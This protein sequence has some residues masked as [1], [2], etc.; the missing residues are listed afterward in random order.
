LTIRIALLPP[1]LLL[2]VATWMLAHP[3]QGIFHDA[4]LYTLQALAH[5]H[6]DTL[7]HDVFLRFG[8]QDRFTIFSP[9]YALT[10]R[11][12]GVDHAAALLTLVSQVALFVGGWCLA[13]AVLSAEYA[14]LGLVLIVAIPGDYGPARVF[15]CVEPFLT[16]RMGAEALVLAAL[17][18]SFSGR[19]RWGF[20]LL[21]AAFAL[22]PVMAAAGAAAW[23]SAAWLLPNPR[24]GIYLLLAATVWLLFASLALPSGEW[25]GIDADWLAIA[26][27]R[28]PYLFLAFWGLDDWGPAAV[29]LTILII[30]SFTLDSRARLLCRAAALT[31]VGGFL[32]T[33]FAC[34]FLHLT[35]FMQVQPWRWQWLGTLVAGLVLPAMIMVNWKRDIA[36]RATALLTIAAWIFGTGEFAIICCVAGLLSLSFGRLNARQIR[37]VFFGSCAVLAI[38]LAW[39][40][41]TNLEFSAAHYMESS[42]PLWLRRATSFVHDGFAPAALLC[43]V[44]IAVRASRPYVAASTWTVLG[45][46]AVAG[47][48]PYAWSIWTKSEFPQSLIVSFAPW[49]NLIASDEEVFW[50]ES[51]LSTWVLLDRPSYISGL[52]TSGV[53]FSRAS[54]LEL[55]RRAFALKSYVSPG[56]FLAWSSVGAH[57]SLSRDAMQGICQMGVFGY[58]VTGADLGMQP[59]AVL[60]RLKLYA[61][62]PQARAAAAA[63]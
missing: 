33:G 22:H 25:G 50:G 13:R 47:L 17:A 36:G 29:S 28:S 1:V 49:R 7:A 10:I 52:Q 23:L 51:P 61:C 56:T 12:L 40:I 53:I 8:S 57:L 30:G 31:M 34:D 35:L 19:R 45:F 26:S 15:T 3:Y 37:L 63:T 42:L 58:L 2:C 43:L 38:A 39:R 27:N 4:N 18:A 62:S 55:E 6:P 41:A 14:L 11:L 16:P 44:L 54:A 9:L 48:A 32:L 21:A 24:L 20:A 5:L 60:N 59:V 46:A